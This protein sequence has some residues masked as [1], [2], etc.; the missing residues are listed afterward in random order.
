MR[1]GVK[2][3]TG[4]SEKRK[5]MLSCGRAMFLIV[6]GLFLANCLQ[7]RPLSHGLIEHDGGRGGQIEART[8]KAGVAGEDVVPAVFGGGRFATLRLVV[9]SGGGRAW[10]GR[11]FPDRLVG[12]CGPGRSL[13]LS[14]C[15][16]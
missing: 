7:R 15:K 16:L 10:L 12:D 11:V 13:H 2:R 5:M 9:G 14:V 1:R 4:A 3:E 8:G 6:F